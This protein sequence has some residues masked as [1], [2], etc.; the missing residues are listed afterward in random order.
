[1]SKILKINTTIWFDLG[2]EDKSFKVRL[3][4]KEHQLEIATLGIDL[5]TALL[6]PL[7]SWVTYNVQ[8]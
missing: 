8:Y 5:S 7:Y 1:M 3:V 2:L 6:L 4:L